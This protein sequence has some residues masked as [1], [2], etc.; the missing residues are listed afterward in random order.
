MKIIVSR[1]DKAGDL[2][3]TTPVFRELR[4]NLPEASIIAHV[5]K[6]TAPILKLGSD[7]GDV[8]LD[9]DFP[10]VLALSKKFKEI[11]ADKIIIVHPSRKVLMAAF[12]A[13]IPQRIGRASNVW[14]FLLTSRK[15]QKRSR[16]EKHEFEYNLDLLTDLFSLIKYDGP[17]FSIPKNLENKG[18][19]ILK[20][21]GFT[22]TFP[23]V[24]HPGHGG[25]AYNLSPHQYSALCRML[26]TRN[27]AV[28]VSLGPGEENLR[29]LFPE[30]EKNKIGY[31]VNVPDLAVLA[32]VFKNCLAFV[33]GSTGPMHIAAALNKPVLAFYPPVP[34]MTPKRWGPICS[35]K[36]VVIPD[37][38]KCNLKCI[39]CSN[40]PCMN[41]IDLAS[42][43]DWLERKLKNESSAADQ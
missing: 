15:V 27:L 29:K 43:V 11:Q 36:L 21:A 3:L 12:L 17:K 39:N 35:E 14:Q 25:S 10:T 22:D 40:H 13:R 6:Y 42:S 2:I 24:L 18:K 33:G 16:N 30:Q 34:A 4:K 1:T 19:E 31:I 9:D 23:I 20:A 5:K 38:K 7:V 32:G 41:R 37:I 26:M 28:A 8:I